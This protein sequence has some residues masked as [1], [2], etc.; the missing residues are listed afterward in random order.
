[1]NAGAALQAR[2]GR[3]AWAVLA[4][5]RGQVLAVFRT[6]A[7]LDAGGALC[8]IGGEHLVD[9]PLNL[10]LCG[11][12]G[13]SEALARCVPGTPWRWCDGA[14]RLGSGPALAVRRPSV[15]RAPAP[16]APEPARLLQGLNACHAARAARQQHAHADC[17]ELSF[18]DAS[19]TPI[20][21]PLRAA[22]DAGTDALERW[23]RGVIGNRAASAPVPPPVLALLGCGPGLTPSGDDLLAG[24][25]VTLHAFARSD[26]ARRLARAIAA[27]APARTGRISA[28]HLA[29]AGDG[30]AVAPVHR[31]LDALRSG[32][33]SACTGATHALLRHGHTSGADALYGI[34][35]AAGAL[36][37]QSSVSADATRVA[38]PHRMFACK[39]AAP[40]AAAR[41]A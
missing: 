11:E 6:C 15:W 9:G 21:Q 40:C 22:L 26:I 29:A 20:A 17:C 18:L 37:D 27:A 23:L 41:S 24:A 3:A 12:P 2:G 35:L 34:M 30:E 8:C 4:R 1:M 38:R 39:Q 7:Y 32:D 5:G 14:L 28:A 31:L 36:R 33:T 25:L 10:R 19:G 13:V 16:A